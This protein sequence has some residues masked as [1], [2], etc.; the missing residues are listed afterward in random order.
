MRRNK[1]G[2][3]RIIPNS[4]KLKIR[5]NSF[6]GC[7]VCCSSIFE[8]EHIDPE[9]INAMTH[10]PDKMTLLCPKCHQNVTSGRMS[11]ETVKLGKEDPC[12]KKSGNSSD[13]FDIGRT[14]PS[15]KIGGRTFN[16]SPEPI[17]V[18]GKPLFKIL[19][20]EQQGAPFRLSGDFYNEE[21][22][23][24]L[25]IVDNEWIVHVL[26]TWDVDV[27]GPVITI[28]ESPRKI[29]LQLR[30]NPPSG[31]II[32]KIHMRT[33]N[34]LFV[35]NS[36]TLKASV[37]QGSLETLNLDAKSQV[38]ISSDNFYPKSGPSKGPSNNGFGF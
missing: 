27:V 5:K 29:A 22:K 21:G 23:L 15:I 12:P 19:P 32:E 28:R 11:K 24:I 7:V 13:I 31:L 30:A 18:D 3:S 10:D 9:F 20:G 14:M 1:H 35:G 36:Q 26:N 8:Y 16:N 34:M 17:I 25:S 2:L 38:K 33:A 37:G 4:V 6:F